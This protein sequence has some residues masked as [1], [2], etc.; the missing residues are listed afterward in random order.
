M[1]HIVFCNTLV[2]MKLKTLIMTAACMEILLAMLLTNL[3][4]LKTSTGRNADQEATNTNMANQYLQE[5]R[6][7][8]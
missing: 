6:K 8:S 3:L 1:G 4:G 2:N 7:T 5:L